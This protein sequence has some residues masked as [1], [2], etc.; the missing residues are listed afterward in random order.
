[1]GGTKRWPRPTS[2]SPSTAGGCGG[3]V[4]RVAVEAPSAARWTT[5]SPP[6]LFVALACALVG[7]GGAALEPAAVVDAPF[8]LSW[9]D[10]TARAKRFLQNFWRCIPRPLTVAVLVS[11]LLMNYDAT[12]GFPGEGPAGARTNTNTD[13]TA[14]TH[15]RTHTHTQT[16]TLT[17]TYT[18][19]RAHTQTHPGTEANLRHVRDREI[20]RRA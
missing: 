4:P 10:I 12:L 16:H 15:T 14:R 1:M 2:R 20:L 19:A 5:L 9:A 17:H 11:M 6:L 7:I 18:H 3:R 8:A 13:T